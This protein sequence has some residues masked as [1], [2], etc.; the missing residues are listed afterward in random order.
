MNFTHWSVAANMVAIVDV[1]FT[2]EGCSWSEGLT[3]VMTMRCQGKGARSLCVTVHT[4]KGGCG[5]EKRNPKALIP[6]KTG[7]CNCVHVSQK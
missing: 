4:E 3:G 2:G 6:Y 5:K 1:G 7:F